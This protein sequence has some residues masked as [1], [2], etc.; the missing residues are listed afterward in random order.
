MAVRAAYAT[1]FGCCTLFVVS[2]EI[3]ITQGHLQQFRDILKKRVPNHVALSDD[4][5]ASDLLRTMWRE[6]ADILS[7]LVCDRENYCFCLHF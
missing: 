6:N 4:A 3:A 5:V 1:H 2:E 7:S